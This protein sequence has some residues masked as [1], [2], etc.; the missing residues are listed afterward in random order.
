MARGRGRG[1]S[2]LRARVPRDDRGDPREWSGSGDPAPRLGGR[3]AA[4]REEGTPG[5]GSG[6]PAGEGEG[7]PEYWDRAGTGAPGCWPGPRSLERG[8]EG[9]TAGS[10]Y[11]GGGEGRGGQGGPRRDL[12]VP[13]AASPGRPESLLSISPAELLLPEQG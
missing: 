11:G 13:G 12:P 1:C 6:A 10:G 8:A 9:G 4:G 5:V 2:A 3:R 7:V